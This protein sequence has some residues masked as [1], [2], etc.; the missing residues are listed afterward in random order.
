MKYNWPQTFVWVWLQICLISKSQPST[1]DIR[2]R[3]IGADFGIK[4][5]SDS[6]VIGALVACYYAILLDRCAPVFNHSTPVLSPFHTNWQCLAMYKWPTILGTSPMY[7]RTSPVH[8]HFVALGDFFRNVRKIVASASAL[9]KSIAKHSLSFRQPSP[10][11]CCSSP[12]RRYQF[13]S[14]FVDEVVKMHWEVFEALSRC[15]AKQCKLLAMRSSVFRHAVVYD[16]KQSWP[17]CYQIAICT[18]MYFHWGAIGP[19]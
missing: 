10:R 12:M 1:F 16:R 9:K 2:I 5:Q 17:S 11:C 6:G 7:R 15:F 19:H 13:V 14:A 8:E 4:Q 3:A 18:F